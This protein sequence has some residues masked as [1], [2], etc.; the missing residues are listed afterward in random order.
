MKK[1]VKIDIQQATPGDC[2]ILM[3]KLS[4][5]D[6]YAFEQNENV[7]S[8]YIARDDFDEELLKSL[9]PSLT[10]YTCSIIPD[11]NWNEEWERGFQPISIN[12]FAGIRASFHEP[13][14]GVEHEI[15]ITP[16]M[17]FGT[18]HHATTSLMIGLMSQID[19]KNKSVLDFGTGTGILAILA[20]KLGASSVIAIDCDEWSIDNAHE[21]I[22]M[23]SCK[24]IL[25]EKTDN[26]IG[27]PCVDI[28][29][30]NITCNIL[31]ENAEDLLIKGSELV[32]S[33]FLLSDEEK[34]DTSFA[35]NLFKK[36]QR[37]QRIEWLAL[38]YVNQ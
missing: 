21:N 31:E 38:H 23:N 6:F 8:A 24:K 3:A 18:G 35:K 14:K 37:L 20:E 15:I 16:K 11:R 7:L 13:M 27:I 17:S 28:I 2:E 29:L 25:I 19:F 10:N 12:N 36:K 9:L 34:I 32:L 30:A 22:H 5:Q 26:I 33:G 1:F 4:E